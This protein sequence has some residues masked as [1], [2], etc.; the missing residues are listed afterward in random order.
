[1]DKQQFYNYLYLTGII[2]SFIIGLA[3]L[4]I[5][6]RN[7]QRTIYINSITAA[8]IK[9]IQDIRI[10]VSEFCG[11][12]YTYNSGKDEFKMLKPEMAEKEA[13]R[14]ELFEIHK[15]ADYLKYLIR[16]HLN[17]EDRYFDPKILTLIDEILLLTDKEPTKKINELI[18]V[19][20]YLLKL[21]WEGAKAESYRGALSKKTKRRLYNQYKK[22]HEQNAAKQRAQ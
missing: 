16:L 14:K 3:G 8:R 5:G 1:M 20:Q 4:I 18:I 10:A 19:M 12:I 7:S 21:E 2:L 9:Y 22:L 15:R 6:I 17:I 11:L 13:K